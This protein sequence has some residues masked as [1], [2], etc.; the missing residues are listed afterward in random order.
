MPDHISTRYAL[1]SFTDRLTTY[2]VFNLLLK[3]RNIDRFKENDFLSFGSFRNCQFFSV[4]TFS[5]ETF[6]VSN[7]LLNAN[8]ICFPESY[9]KIH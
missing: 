6:L 5:L 1:H 8:M 9:V 7:L 2:K 4:L 3:C